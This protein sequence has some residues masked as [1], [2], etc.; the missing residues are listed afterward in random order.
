MTEET[1]RIRGIRREHGEDGIAVG[2]T[3]GDPSRAHRPA[4]RGRNA[5]RP[6]RDRGGRRRE[7][8]ARVLPTPPDQSLADVTDLLVGAAAG[9]RPVG[10]PDLLAFVDQIRT[11]RA[12][13]ELH[14]GDVAESI[15]TASITVPETGGAMRTVLGGGRAHAVGVY[16]SVKTG[17]LQ[18]YDGRIERALIHLC[19]AD[20]R[21]VDYQSQPLVMRFRTTSGTGAWIPD[22]WRQLVDGPIEVIEVKRSPRDLRRPGYAGKLAC[23][24]AV[25]ASLGHRFRLMYLEDVMGNAHRRR[26]LAR[27]QGRRGVHPPAA[28]LARFEDAARSGR[29]ACVG[30][31]RRLL[32]DDGDAMR[33]MAFVHGLIARARLLV[34][35]DAR[36][37]DASPATVLP[38][39]RPPSRIRF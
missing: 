20:G 23:A 6:G 21:I 31:A 11:S 37:C 29:V 7:G 10:E 36:L 5:D 22:L 25:T 12:E 26:N 32:A 17:W 9:P 16:G 39:R 8:A 19:E 1:T 34:D 3:A 33:G 15:A 14:P 2:P 13:L 28:A 35:L 4:S 24:A 30:D 38:V 27:V 18:P